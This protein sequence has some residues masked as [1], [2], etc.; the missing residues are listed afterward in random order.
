MRRCRYPRRSISAYGS[1]RTATCS[2]RRWATSCCFRTMSLI[3]MAVGGPNA[4]KDFH[5]DPGDEFFFQLEG[6][7]VLRIVR[8]GRATDMPI[9]EGEVFLLPPEIPH[10]PQRPAGTVGIVV[11]RRR[12]PDEFDGFSW[13]CENCGNPLYLER[14]AVRTSRPNSRPIFARFFRTSDTAPAPRAARSWQP[15]PETSRTQAVNAA[16]AHDRS[17][18]AL[19]PFAA[20]FHHPFDSDGRRLVYLAGHSLGLQAK[21]TA[22]LCRGGIGRLAPPRRPRPS[23]GEA[24][25]DQ[26]SRSGQPP[27]SP[28][29]S[30]RT[31]P[32]SSP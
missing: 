9:R 10:S 28:H 14:I 8:S 23:R 31:R 12:G 6:D 24:A 29:W 30:G 32:K 22:R 7:M 16:S 20:E 21:S 4:R 15:P 1:S 19:A 18:I 26:L 13:Y 5:H 11:E 3:V 25:V 17:A 27:R 2:S